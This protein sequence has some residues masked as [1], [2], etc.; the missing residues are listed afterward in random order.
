MLAPPVRPMLA[1]TTPTVPGPDA[2]PGGCLYQPKFDG[3][4]A[5][6][7]HR[8]A[9]ETGPRV[10]LQSRAGNLMT[11]GFPE[12]V[13]AIVEQVPPGVVFDGELVIWDGRGVNF[14]ALAGR[15]GA[16]RRA[17]E[18]ARTRPATYLA[19]DVLAVE[20]T[21][22]R[23]LRLADRLDLL[24]ALLSD[25]RPPLQMVPTTRDVATARGW[26]ADYAATPALGMEGV[27]IKGAADPYASGKRGWLKY[28]VRQTHDVV[29]GAVTGSLDAPSRLVLGYYPDPAAGLDDP[30]AVAATPA[31]DPDGLRLQVAGASIPLGARQARSIGRLLVPATAD[32]PWPDRMPAGWLGHWAGA[33]TRVRLV[34]P[35]VVVEVS[36][37]TAF[38][39]G[40][41]RHQVRYMRVRTDKDPAHVLRPDA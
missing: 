6:A 4:R 16:T 12:I 21:D 23:H 37:D 40:R 7:F 31:A 19:F 36:S 32:H 27:V 15:M 17:E 13:A 20:G 5:L 34:A 41:W 30:A 9:A 24:T 11:G 35:H 22:V 39:Y 26:L 18:L 33:S 8:P 29:V 3:Y 10:A 2:L 14:S 1:A 28:R 25:A 38:E